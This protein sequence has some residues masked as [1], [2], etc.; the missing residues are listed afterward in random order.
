MINIHGQLHIAFKTCY[1]YWKTS[2]WSGISLASILNAELNLKIVEGF[3]S[4][5]LSHSVLPGLFH[6]GLRPFASFTDNQ[7]SLFCGWGARA[8]K[9]NQSKKNCVELDEI[10]I[11][12]M[13]SDWKENIK[14]AENK[15]FETCQKSCSEGWRIGMYPLKRNVVPGGLIH[16]RWPVQV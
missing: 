9:T 5:H 14:A 12:I 16:L 8:H 15:E 13:C 2:D 6:P 11:A 10:W 4:P 3:C 1:C 7:C